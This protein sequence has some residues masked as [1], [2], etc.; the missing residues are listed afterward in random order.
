MNIENLKQYIS[1]GGYFDDSRKWYAYKYLAP[2]SQRVWGMYISVAL[3]CMLAALIMNANMLL[4][5]KQ[6]ITYGIYSN[7]AAGSE[8]SASIIEMDDA[9][10][11]TTPRMF[12]A[13]TLLKS[14]VKSREDYDYDKLKEQFLHVRNSSDKIVFKRFYDY[15]N[16][17]NPES[18]VI[19]YQKYAKRT[20]SIK[21]IEFT[22]DND[23]LV[24]FDS[25]A[26]D[27]NG[28]RFENLSWQ[29]NI[30]FK[31]DSIDDKS[32]QNSKFNFTVRDY[33]IRMLEGK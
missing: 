14:Y 1:S 27:E 26:V 22:S 5:I 28:N 33:K 16:I 10:A 17:D 24:D 7:N 8:E 23:A 4:P 3:L 31:M 9:P 15:M 25:I 2:I 6:V 13:T 18:P 20:I 12:I 32:Y 21:N 11:G 29:A 19:R 30:N